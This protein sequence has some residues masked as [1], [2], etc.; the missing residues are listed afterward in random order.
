MELFGK[1]EMVE[2]IAAKFEMSKAKAGDMYDF[3][4]AT[5][6]NQVAKG[7]RVALRGIGTLKI[8]SMSAR[9][10]KS[11]GKTVNLPARKRVVLVSK[12]QK[13]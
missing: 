10:S 11:F 13:A 2:A 4:M 3:I 6:G 9:V 1:K 7:N 12:V 8:K 5:A